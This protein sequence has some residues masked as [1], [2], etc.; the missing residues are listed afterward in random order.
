M[1]SGLE[2]EGHGEKPERE[3]GGS[4][5]QWEGEPRP[6]VPLANRGVREASPGLKNEL[7]PGTAG[8]LGPKWA[9]LTL[10]EPSPGPFPKAVCGPL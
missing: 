10:G 4:E 8:P 3:A 7:A 1:R 9:C 2:P 6:C 5:S